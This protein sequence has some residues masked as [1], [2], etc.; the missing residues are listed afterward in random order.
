[1]SI[2]EIWTLTGTSSCISL[3]RLRVVC[4]YMMSRNAT[5]HICILAVHICKS[6][7]NWTPDI[8]KVQLWC[9]IYAQSQV[10]VSQMC[11]QNRSL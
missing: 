1:M 2:K 9:Y 5:V 11:V 4:D 7:N 6:M 3:Y 8:V 10:K